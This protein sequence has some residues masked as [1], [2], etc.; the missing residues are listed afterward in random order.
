M[1]A[2]LAVPADSISVRRWF[3][4]YG[5]TLAIAIAWLCV[6]IVDQ[7]A[8]WQAWRDEFLPTLAGAGPA[9][10]LVGFGI[11]LTFCC[12]F[13]PLPTGWIVATVATRE[14]AVGDGPWTT[15]LLVA[16]AGAIG[17]TIANLHDYHLITWM[18]RSDRVGSVRTT[19][20]Y[21]AAIRW[22]RRSPFMLVAV[23]NI[24][25]IPIDVVRMLAATHRYPRLVFAWANFLGRFVRY[26][27]IAYVTYTWNLGWIAPLALLALAA[28]L[29]AMRVIPAIFA[30]PS[31]EDERIRA[32]GVD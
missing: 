32:D 25:P 10:K 17:S 16:A 1:A 29:G 24:I 5:V 9:L 8:S 11:F 14:A 19:R 6:L 31:S 18:L 26:A 15:M 30:R 21:R 20:T 13:L 3:V 22:F 4:F 27:V 7:G 2:A 28:M 23:F 12:T